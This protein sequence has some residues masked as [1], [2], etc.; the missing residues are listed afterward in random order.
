LIDTQIMDGPLDDQA[1]R[2]VAEL[3]G[4]A[5]PKYSQASFLRHLFKDNPYAWSLHAFAQDG[6][7]LIGHCAVVPVK[8]RLG[9]KLGMSGKVEAFFVDQAYR[10]DPTSR[11]GPSVGL[12][13]LSQLTK[14]AQKRG[15]D[16][17]HAYVSPRVGAI[18]ERDGYRP[19]VAGPRAYTLVTR[20][21]PSARRN[22]L[23][24]YALATAESVTAHAAR[25]I[26]R[27]GVPRIEAPVD[28]DAELVEPPA[29]ATTSWTITGSD[30]W[31]W[32]VASGFIYALEAPGRTGWRAVVS[33]EAEGKPVHLLG[34]RPTNVGVTSA[35]SLLAGLARFAKGRSA[36][37][38]R[39]QPW[40]GLAH[41]T[42][43]V[44]ACH[45]MAWAPRDRFT[46][47]V[48]S[49]ASSVAVEPSPF[50]YVTF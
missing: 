39:I 44:R 23:L 46:I 5:D 12:Q 26:T 14:A 35:A 34:W 47:Y 49:T 8:A 11:P 41:Q 21:S 17:L 7:R 24:L 30:A 19:H 28:A 6:A 2:W 36:P 10:R 32:Y 40:P 27:T 33:S 13:I 9:G 22:A 48:N 3:Y 20:T 50:F 45:L 42:D 37:S 25:K 1:L 43:I 31:S 38:V 18:F 16:P 29:T 4:L 15:V